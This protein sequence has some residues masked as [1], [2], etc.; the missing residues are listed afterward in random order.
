LLVQHVRAIVYQT[1]SKFSLENE[2]LVT[3]M[4]HEFNENRRSTVFPYKLSPPVIPLNIADM[5]TENIVKGT[6][7]LQFRPSSKMNGC[8]IALLTR[9][10]DAKLE[11]EARKLEKINEK[12][13]REVALAVAAQEEAELMKGQSSEQNCELNE[14]SLDNK[15][16]I[17]LPSLT[18]E[19]KKLPKRKT[20]LN[21]MTKASKEPSIE[22]RLIELQ[23]RTA[24]GFLKMP[25]MVKTVV[26]EINLEDQL[27]KIGKLNQQSMT[28]IADQ[29]RSSTPH[30]DLNK[31]HM[32][33][34][35]FKL[36]K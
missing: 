15:K 31:F 35:E 7:Y 3:K 30:E 19:K 27:S 2:N 29:Q 5:Q 8:F 28:K 34:F 10:R 11:K 14:Q 12:K 22:E 16:K 13:A 4:L 9:D 21:F 25:S 6:K 33:E 36:N 26:S 18:K 1:Y 23:N 20:S 24:S 17:S 32:K